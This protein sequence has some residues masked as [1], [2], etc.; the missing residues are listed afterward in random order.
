MTSTAKATTSTEKGAVDCASEVRFGVVLYGGVSLAI[1]INSV[2]GE[3]YEMES[4][5]SEDAS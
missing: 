3:M 4:E 1:Y 5:A 2:A